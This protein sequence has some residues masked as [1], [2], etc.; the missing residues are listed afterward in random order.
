MVACK[1][2]DRLLMIDG[3]FFVRGVA[4]AKSCGWI[5]KILLCPMVL[6]YEGAALADTHKHLQLSEWLV[7]R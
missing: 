1:G 3:P 7:E 5:Q 2:P 4:V 6:F